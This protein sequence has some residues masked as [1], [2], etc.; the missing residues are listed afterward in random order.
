APV[1]LA[2][3]EPAL[4]EAIGRL[5]TTRE[6]PV[7]P[8]IEA[9]D[10]TVA[11]VDGEA[12]EGIDA[13]DLVEALEDALAQEET[14]VTVERTSIAPRFSLD[15]AERL[16][17]RAEDL[18]SRQMSVAVG[19][20]EA[21]VPAE[22]LRTWMRA[23][24][25]DTGLLLRLDTDKVQADL[26][27]LFPEAGDPPKDASF[28]VEGDRVTIVPGASGT[29]CCAENAGALVLEGPETRTRPV[30][31]PLRE[32]QPARTTQE[33]EELGIIEKVGEFPTQH[34]AGQ[35]RVTN[36]HRIADITRGVVIEP[37]GTFSVNEFVGERTR[38]KGFVP[39]GVIYNGEFTEDVGGGISQY[40]T[41][42][43]NAAFFAGLEFEEYQSHSIY[44]SRYPYGREATLS[45]PSPDLKIKNPSPYG[46]LIWP[47]YTPSSITVSLYSTRWAT[48][49]QTA[50]FRSASGR[51]TSVRTV[52]TRTFTDGH[53]ETDE[54]F[55]RYRPSEGVNC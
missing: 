7:E 54:V 53:T 55:A 42:L 9:A 5:D 12:G 22:T 50:Q 21:L 13:R 33:A 27:A 44:I 28:N 35:A 8:S 3:D 39:A 15:D 47:T 23:E 51:C 41:T 25:A 43:F 30:R 45:F 4:R 40:A 20:A 34:A 19:Q 38:E 11:A 24:P 17:A 29:A 26:E 36:I 2:V 31:V 46:V 49:E 48:G 52:R 6:P 18:A 14:T 16:A 32:A 1:E 37:G 10:G